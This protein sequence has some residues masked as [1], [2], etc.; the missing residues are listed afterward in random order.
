ML[1]AFEA[2]DGRDVGMVQRGECLGFPVET[3]E[4]FGVRGDRLGQHL[5]R[6]I[7]IQICVSGAMPPAPRGER[8]S[9]GPSLAPRVR[10][11]RDCPWIIRADGS[12][13]GITPD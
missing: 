6:H 13:D 8:I 4:A 11:K 12:A 5:D 2:V 1:E 7:A 10:G 9:Y 3:C